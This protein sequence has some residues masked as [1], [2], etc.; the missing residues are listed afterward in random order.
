VPSI[1]ENLDRWNEG[2]D[3]RYAGD[4]W[5]RPWGSARGQWYRSIL[6]RIQ[7]FL[8]APAILEIA[9]GFGRWTEFLLEYCETLIGVDVTPKCVEACR[10]RFG[11]RP[12]TRFEVNDG[13][14]L[15]M[16]EDA[17]ID[18]AFSFDSLVHVEAETLA[19]YLEELARVL[20]PDGVAFLHHSNYGAYER[21]TRVFAPLQDSFDRLPSLARAGLL[22]SGTYRGMHWRA[23]SVTAARFAELCDIVGLQC[24][25]QELINWEGGVL[26]LD[27]LSVIARPGSRWDRPNRVVKN[28]LFRVEA[29]AIRRSG[30]LYDSLP[31]RSH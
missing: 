2:Y 24:V 8:P 6:P 5:S 18:F 27:C 14:S 10:E 21:S 9:P 20:K 16:V 28:R 13:H 15:P 17:S 3:W 22:R 11:D 26:L 29:R 1:E 19:G 25:G 30:S 7:G 31:A 4:P 12:G 23:P